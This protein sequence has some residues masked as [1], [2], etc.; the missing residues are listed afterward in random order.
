MPSW[1]L[2]RI[3]AEGD[4]VDHLL[5]FETSAAPTFI[6]Q[7]EST[8]HL[9]DPDPSPGQIF[10]D[11]LIAFVMAVV[12]AVIVGPV[13]GVLGYFALS[14]DGDPGDWE[15]LGSLIFAVLICLGVAA[16]AYLVAAIVGLIR[17]VPAGYRTL[18]AIFL[19]G[20]PVV[21]A[22]AVIPL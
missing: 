4:R 5:M 6:P 7:P 1:G 8:D 18:P 16:I 14:A 21:F 2:L 13:A 11:T 17:Y 19:V 22:F 20:V 3:L 9:V 12:S 15:G 10:C